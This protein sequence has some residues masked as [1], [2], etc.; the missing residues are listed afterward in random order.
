MSLVVCLIDFQS[1]FKQFLFSDEFTRITQLVSRQL[2]VV[3]Y[4][5]AFS[6]SLLF[7]QLLDIQ[8]DH[9]SEAQQEL[10]LQLE[11][12]SHLHEDEFLIDD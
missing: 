4:E 9:A 12:Y 3:F 6:S 1:L 11:V 7:R 10:D 8:G 5:F 2:Q